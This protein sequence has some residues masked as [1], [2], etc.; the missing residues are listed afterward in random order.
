MAISRKLASIQVIKDIIPIKDADAI[1][2]VR[3]LGWNVVVK[4]GE[5][6]IGDKV[7]YCEVDSLFPQKPEF[8]FLRKVNFRIK[9][10]RLRGVYSQGICF[11]LSILPVGVYNEGD[12]V[13]NLLEI[14]KYEPP[15]PV[16]LAGEAKGAFPSFLSKTDE[17]RIQCLEDILT[18]YLGTLCYYSEKI[19]GTSST[20]YLNEGEFGV[21]GKNMEWLDTEKNTYWQIARKYEIEKK[22]RS[23]GRNIAIQGEIIGEGIQRN[24]YKLGKNERRLYIFNAFDIDT[25]TYLSFNEFAQLMKDMD[26]E[27]VPILETNFKLTND[28]DYL[29]E[30]SKGNSV[31][32][33]KIRR[34][35]IVIRPLVEQIDMSLGR[36]SFKAIN[37]EFLLK[38]DE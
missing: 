34:E 8:E 5:F 23:I 35:G 26:L 24:K 13:T 28:I 10:I 19:D 14:S 11:P 38:Y 30:L 33:P 22:L 27:T 20:F 1:E 17:T 21:C 37:P 4:K 25:Y 15:I 6:K 12:D 18:K 9:T 29:T 3:V 2:V 16:D 32:N 31:I 7:I 36:L